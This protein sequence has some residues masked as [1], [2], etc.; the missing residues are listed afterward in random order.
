MKIYKII[1]VASFIITSILLFSCTS[2][3]SQEDSENIF[4]YR[5]ERFL[6]DNNIPIYF[7]EYNFTYFIDENIKEKDLILFFQLLE[8]DC[9]IIADNIANVNTTRTSEENGPFKRSRIIII[10]G[11]ISIEKDDS[12]GRYVYDPVHP[13]SIHNGNYEGYVEYP[14]VNIINELVDLLVIYRI[15]EQITAECHSKNISIPIDYRDVNIN[16]ESIIHIGDKILEYAENNGY[17]QTF[18][19]L[20]DIHIDGDSIIY[21][22]LAIIPFWKDNRD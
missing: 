17:M 3:D 11:R 15:W 9:D 10:N 2:V 4:H 13:D 16:S 18:D 12:P 19:N 1:R 6:R 21:S 5:Y 22:I 14:N 20:K 8:L 7:N